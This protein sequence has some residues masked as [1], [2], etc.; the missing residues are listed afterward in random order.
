MTLPQKGLAD[1]TESG[2]R[3]RVSPRG[4]VCWPSLLHWWQKQWPVMKY[5]WTLVISV[6]CYLTATGQY[7]STAGNARGQTAGPAAAAELSSLR[8]S[9]S[10]TRSEAEKDTTEYLKRIIPSLL[11][12]GSYP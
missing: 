5:Q 11:E 6:T 12:H 4:M 1:T 7:E 3:V 9:T 10:P 2:P 8:V